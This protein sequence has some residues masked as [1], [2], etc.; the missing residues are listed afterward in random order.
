[1]SEW[2][3][4]ETAPKD[5]T[6]LLLFG[7]PHGWHM[8]YAIGNWFEGHGPWCG[9]EAEYLGDITH[10]MPLPTAPDIHP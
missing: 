1:M 10:W 5:G 6:W 2:Q 9:L 7:N 4:I 8:R 3:P